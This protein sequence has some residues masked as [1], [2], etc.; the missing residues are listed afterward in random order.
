M[1]LLGT[2]HDLITVGSSV[3][4]VILDVMVTI[5]FYKMGDKGWPYC[6]GCLIIFGIANCTYAFLFAA[7]WAR[8][9]SPLGRMLVFV[10]VLPV[11][12][13][14]PVFVWVESF[15]FEMIDSALQCL[16]MSL[17]EST[18][19]GEAGS[20]TG[21]GNTEEEHDSLWS[22][23]QSK[24]NAHA[25]FLTEALVEAV[26][27]SVLQTTAAILL[28]T[29]T[30]LNV[31]SIILSVAVVASKGY[32][33][34]YSIHRTTFVF[35]F[36]CIAA[37]AFGMF[38]VATWVA[39]SPPSSLSFGSS[40]DP[41]ISIMVVLTGCSMGLIC[42][43]GFSAWIF[44]ILDDHLKTW[45][46]E[47][48]GKRPDFGVAW[49]DVYFVRLLTWFLAIMPVTVI[50]ATAKLCMLPVFL[51]NSLDPE[52]AQHAPFYRWLFSFLFERG[53]DKV[54]RLNAVNQYFS[55]ARS[56]AW[57]LRRSLKLCAE[58]PWNER[59][60]RPTAVR[61]WAK[62]VGT[63]VIDV[64]EELDALERQQREMAALILATLQAEEADE[65][66]SRPDM[67]AVQ[68]Q[69][70]RMN[71]AHGVE[72][73]VYNTGD[74]FTQRSEILTWIASGFESAAMQRASQLCAHDWRVILLL[75][76]GSISLALALLLGSI[77][78]PIMMSFIAYGSVLPGIQLVRTWDREDDVYHLPQVLS[79][80]Y[81]LC[82]SA[83]CVLAPNV[84]RFQ[85]GLQ[86]IVNIK[87]MPSAFYICSGVRGEI[88]RRYVW[89][90]TRLALKA[91]LD[92]VSNHNMTEV[93]LERCP[94]W[95]TNVKVAYEH[96][97]LC[98]ADEWYQVSD[99]SSDTKNVDVHPQSDAMQVYHH[100]DTLDCQELTMEEN[101]FQE[102][103]S[104]D[105][106]ELKLVAS[107]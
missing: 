100:R 34:S 12:Q 33:I 97:L 50:A 23:I 4:D 60:M 5:E 91:T 22:Y 25:G 78:T 21:G 58:R 67:E 32:L 38:A 79:G 31:T 70:R 47:E 44:S 41:M 65:E 40:E 101:D 86:D 94:G 93:I 85:A 77:W 88:S 63:H 42:V 72:M 30:P 8:P 75:A 51:F 9:H 80:C 10:M 90:K 103:T 11:A 39:A 71:M 52:H 106:S 7:T 20:R 73:L 28:G 46:P 19:P 82:L 55:Q 2:I 61:D 43:G 102:T 48:T 3:A 83:L 54:M 13:L 69:V 62:A 14:V 49:F 18:E 107:D 27:Q 68:S 66:G 15:H 59:E 29:L 84:Y 81:L 53:H 76:G 104:S 16:G 45:R 36:L 87:N 89:T 57:R 37:D 96:G 17:T 56:E 6:L 95:E 92:A 99:Q 26:P 1:A 64:E 74:D 98:T 35:N 24:Y 105:G